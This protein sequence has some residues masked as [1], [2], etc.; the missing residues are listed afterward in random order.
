MKIGA[1]AILALIVVGFVGAFIGWNVGRI[2]VITE[3]TTVHH[4]LIVEP[5]VSIIT[6]T[7]TISITE[8]IKTT[9]TK[10]FVII[11]IFEGQEDKTTESFYI[12]TN[13]W[14][15][16]WEYKGSEYASFSFHVYEKENNDLIEEI[17]GEGAEGKDITYIHEGK[18]EYYIKVFAANLEHWKLAIEALPD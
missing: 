2:G 15:I 14:R 9:P 17:I 10:E 7:Q 16:K 3:T 6:I 4:T 12:P 1:I 8:E 5:K 13:K 11:K 18:K